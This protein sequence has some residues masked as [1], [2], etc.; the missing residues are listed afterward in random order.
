MRFRSS[1]QLY[2]LAGL[3]DARGKITDKRITL[4]IRSKTLPRYLKREF[5]GSAY[6]HR[7]T[8]DSKFWGVYSVQGKAAQRFL[9]AVYPYLVLQ[10]KAAKEVLAM[11]KSISI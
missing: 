9:K 7:G 8:K 4:R 1:H 2:Y 5:G 10:R 11:G 6:E 3:L